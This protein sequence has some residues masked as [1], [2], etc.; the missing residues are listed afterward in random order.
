MKKEDIPLTSFIA[1]VFILPGDYPAG[2]DS[3]FVAAM[4]QHLPETAGTTP[5]DVERVIRDY[6]NHRGTKLHHSYPGRVQTTLYNQDKLMA[7]CHKLQDAV[8][9]DE[10]EGATR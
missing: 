5:N 9:Y 3:N 7:I 1:G 6:A 4:A 10:D 2:I 8:M